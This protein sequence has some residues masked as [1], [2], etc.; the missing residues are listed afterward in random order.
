MLKDI[1]IGQYIYGKSPVH[2]LDPRFKLLAVIGFIVVLFLCRNFWSVGLLFVFCAF[3][4]MLAGIP[5]KMILKSLKPVVPIILLTSILNM[6]FV[7]GD[8]LVK[9]WKA[10]ITVQGVRYAIV[11]SLRIVILIASSSLLTY[12]TSPIELTNALETLLKPLSKIHFPVHE[13]SMMMSIALRFIPTIISETDRIMSAQKS[14]GAD[15]D[16][17]S[18]LQRIK[19]LLPIL[20]P[21]FVSAFKRADELALAMECRCYNGG[22]GRTRLKQLKFRL[23]DLAGTGVLAAV[24]A[25]VIVLNRIF[26]AVM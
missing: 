11:I 5:I 17:G 1:T 16:S 24:T 10:T 12:T 25:A 21:L 2:R 9:I 22:E 3:C 23:N 4:Y 13:L 6:F 19:A 8:P 7:D 15:L 14:R 26:P 18:F 20:V